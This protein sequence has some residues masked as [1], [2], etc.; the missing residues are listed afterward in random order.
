MYEVAPCVC[1]LC[2]DTAQDEDDNCER[3]DGGVAESFGDVVVVMVVV[4]RMSTTKGYEG[5]VVT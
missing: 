1:P 5:D 2:T 3:I 4:M